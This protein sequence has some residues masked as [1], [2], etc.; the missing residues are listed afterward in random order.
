M[1]VPSTS[2]NISSALVNSV[3]ILEQLQNVDIDATNTIVDAR[4][5]AD[6]YESS[7]ITKQK[8]TINFTANWY[9]ASTTLES[10]NL[11]VSVWSVGGTAYIGALKSG[12]IDVSNKGPE[13][14]GIAVLNEYTL[15]TSTSVRVT[16]DIMVVTSAALQKIAMGSSL[17]AM[18][19]TVAITFSGESFTVPGVLS[20]SKV[21]VARGEV[22]M[23]NVTLMLRG[24]PTTPGD[25][26]SLLYL[27]MVGSAVTSVDFN[28]TTGRY[29]TGVGQYVVISNFNLQF[30]DKQLTAQRVT[31]E[32]QGALTVS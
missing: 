11:D 9:D 14:S 23:E 6:R 7:Q 27:A 1:S 12:Q 13:V 25:T 19:V 3:D 30:A 8:Q 22:Q 20:A 32:V 29:K 2:L 24:T 28:E 5:I 4:G 15:P 31:C 21:T 17:S 18:A 10:V 16:S 26:T